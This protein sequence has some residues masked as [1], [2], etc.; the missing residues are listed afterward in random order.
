MEKGKFGFA[1]WLYP[2]IALWT[3]MVGPTLGS[4]LILGFVIA[5]ER[6]EWVIKQCAHVVMFNIYW[7]LLN[8]IMDALSSIPILGLVFGI[9]YYVV[10]VVIVILA[11]VL[12]LGRLKRGHDISLPG[13]RIINR[14]YDMAKEYTHK[15][16][17]RYQ[18]QQQSAPQQLQQAPPSPQWQQPPPLQPQHGISPPSPPPPPQHNTNPPP[19]PGMNH[20][21]QHPSPMPPAPEP[22]PA[23]PPTAP[24]IDVPDGF[25]LDQGSGLY[26]KVMHKK[27]PATGESGQWYTWFYPESG[28]FRQQFHAD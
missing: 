19:P 18:L 25:I 10:W 11:F 20:P 17:E 7:E 5:V 6:N 14:A 24:K 9:I 23:P 1:L 26:Y 21:P 2:F 13:S 28:E 15:H 16:Q 22:E 8:Y 27:D 12:G 3:V 4:L